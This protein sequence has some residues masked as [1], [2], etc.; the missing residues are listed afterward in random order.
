[1]VFVLKRQEWKGLSEE[2][3]WVKRM[4]RE[5]DAREEGK[6]KIYMFRL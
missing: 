5:T 1:M 4:G 6:S 2:T 3:K